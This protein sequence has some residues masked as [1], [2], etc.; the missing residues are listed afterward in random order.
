MSQEK[1]SK[2]KKTSKK[3]KVEHYNAVLIEE[4]RSDFKFVVEHATS[5]EDRLNKKM[6]VKFEEVDQNFA[7]IRK[8]LHNFGNKF[9]DIDQ[10]F[11][12]I[13]RFLNHMVRENNKRFENVDKRLE[14]IDKR[15]ESIDK[16]FGK[17]EI[18]LKPLVHKVIEHD[19]IL[20]RLINR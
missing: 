20:T 19:Q 6:D 14:S 1:N 9:E 17:L 10:N 5:V 18:M 15:F 12:D 2:P 13:T 8:I 11:S 4:L 16:R 3:T 7:D